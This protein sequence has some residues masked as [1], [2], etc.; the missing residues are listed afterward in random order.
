MLQLHLPRHQQ[1]AYLHVRRG[2]LLTHFF[3]RGRPVL[4]EV[5][6]EREQKI[7]IERPTRSFQGPAL[8]RSA[9]LSA[10]GGRPSRLPFSRCALPRASGVVV[11][12]SVKVA[13]NRTEIANEHGFE[14]F[15][16]EIPPQLL[17]L[18]DEGAGTSRVS[19]ARHGNGEPG[20]PVISSRSR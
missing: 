17:A 12:S 11:F 6:S 2:L 8:I 20:R 18:A 9:S 4:F 3:N 7:S 19:S 5:G 1:G 15:G 16:V 13:I 10:I 14:A